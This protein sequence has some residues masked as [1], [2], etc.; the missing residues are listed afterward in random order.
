MGYLW[1]QLNTGVMYPMI[2]TFAAVP[3]LRQYAP[4]DLVEKWVPRLTSAD[5]R[6]G[7]LAG[8][9]FTEKQGG[10][11]LRRITTT[12]IPAGDGAWI[13]DGHKWFCSAPM[14]DVFLTIA[15]TSAGLSCF[16]VERGVGF[17]IVRLKDKLGTRSLPSA[18]IEFRGA[19]GWLVGEDGPGN[20]PAGHQ[21]EPRS[22]RACRLP[23][24]ARRARCGDSPLPAPQR[25]RSAIG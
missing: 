7:A 18:E 2:M 17:Q 10:S 11:D 1:G 13:I 22:I 15:K 14:C 16:L 21:S 4:R 12:A 8:Q 19:R 24:D 6:Q 3:V 25:L 23:R 5:Y 9:A 20:G